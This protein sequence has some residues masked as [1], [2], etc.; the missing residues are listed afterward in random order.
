MKGGFRVSAIMIWGWSRVPCVN[1]L[2]PPLF[3][4]GADLYLKY[5]HVEEITFLANVK[6]YYL[7]RIV[8]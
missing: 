1:N 2:L 6:I 7:Q 5:T 3:S 8:Q 4:L